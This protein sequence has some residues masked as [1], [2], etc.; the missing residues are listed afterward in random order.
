M[1]DHTHGLVEVWQVSL[2]RGALELH[3][4]LRMLSGPERAR[5]S[6]FARDGDRADYVMVRS[7]LRRL[8]GA[9]LGLSVADVRLETR[10]GGKPALA[11]GGSPR[12]SVSHTGGLALIAL[13]D[14]LEVGVDVEAWRPLPERLADKVLSPEE[15]ERMDRSANAVAAFYDHW[16]LKEAYLKCTGQGLSGEPATVSV[17]PG[18]PS[19]IGRIVVR[20]LDVP[21]GYSAALA[22]EC[23]EGIGVPALAS[24]TL[25]RRELAA[26]PT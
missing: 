24:R 13:A 4:R 10:A 9:R 1:P 7:T 18:P 6:R 5:A 19:R 25:D 11:G 26:A 17:T 12:F 20:S 21:A 22:V 14:G 2:A 15:R 8:L 23:P 16:V 3:D